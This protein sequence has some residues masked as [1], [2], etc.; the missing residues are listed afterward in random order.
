MLGVTWPEQSVAMSRHSSCLILRDKHCYLLQKWKPLT[1]SL[2]TQW[3]HLAGL[4]PVFTP[5]T[6]FWDIWSYVSPGLVSELA[7]LPRVVYSLAID[8]NTHPRWRLWCLYSLKLACMQ[9]KSLSG[10]ITHDNHIS[11]IQLWP[12]VCLHWQGCMQSLRVLCPPV[13]PH[14]FC[15]ARFRGETLYFTEF[16]FCISFPPSW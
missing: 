13:L 16:S 9:E 12:P 11:L 5:M 3:L 14:P 2:H 15:V 8:L 7:Q 10:H 4:W 6:V 1:H